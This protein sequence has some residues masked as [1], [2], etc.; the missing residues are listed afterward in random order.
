MTLYM[1]ILMVLRTDPPVDGRTPPALAGFEEDDGEWQIDLEYYR[2]FL[3]DVT[4]VAI[5]TAV[6]P[7]QLKTIQSR[8]EGCIENYERTGSCVCEAFDRYE[9]VDSMATV[10]ELAR[11]FRVLVTQHVETANAATR[12]E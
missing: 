10:H 1:A 5:D 2:S 6:S 3:Q 11:L 9:H 4:G 7:A 8:L 12:V